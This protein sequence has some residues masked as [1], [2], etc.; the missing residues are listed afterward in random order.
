[1]FEAELTTIEKL[2][3]CFK[4]THQSPFVVPFYWNWDLHYLGNQNKLDRDI[5]SFGKAFISASQWYQ[6]L[7]L[8]KY[9]NMRSRQNLS[10][11]FSMFLIWCSMFLNLESSVLHKKCLI[12]ILGMKTTCNSFD[13]TNWKI[14]TP[15]F[16]SWHSLLSN[17]GVS[18]F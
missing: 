4:L 12:G 9:L 14:L 5:G 16:E 18:I 11:Q 6:C 1:M 8:T 2:R 7:L 13:K 10:Y 15:A 3:R 17:G